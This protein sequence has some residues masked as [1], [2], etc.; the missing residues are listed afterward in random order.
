M[1]FFIWA[2]KRLLN[3]SWNCI[4][5]ETV[6]KVFFCDRN[7]SKFS[8]WLGNTAWQNY[9]YRCLNTRRSDSMTTSCPDSFWSILCL[10]LKLA[11]MLTCH[12]APKLSV[13]VAS[14]LKTLW[15]SVNCVGLHTCKQIHSICGILSCFSPWVLSRKVCCPGMLPRKLPHILGDKRCCK[16]H[17]IDHKWAFCYW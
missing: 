14:S 10:L 16:T 9:P 8:C 11:D 1:L 5:E 17:C 7:R 3:S 13:R 15:L 6:V 2:N 4:K 12:A